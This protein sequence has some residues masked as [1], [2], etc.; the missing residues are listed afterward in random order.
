MTTKNNRDAGALAL[1]TGAELA[2][3]RDT[4]A[5]IH[6]AAAVYGL[7]RARLENLIQ[8]KEV[9]TP[10][11]GL[12]YH[13]ATLYP[14]SVEHPVTID[15]YLARLDR[16]GITTLKD[17]AWLIGKKYRIIS[18]YRRDIT[19]SP[20]VSQLMTHMLRCLEQ[21]PVEE[22]Q[23]LVAEVWDHPL[24]A[25]HLVALKDTWRPADL[26]AML[27]LD[28]SHFNAMSKRE[29]L[30]NSAGI[31]VRLLEHY[32]ELVPAIHTPQ[33][34][35]FKELLFRHGVTS[36]GVI[37]RL[38]GRVRQV[39]RNYLHGDIKPSGPV[40]AL[41]KLITRFL[42]THPLSEYMALVEAVSG[43]RLSIMDDVQRLETHQR[44]NDS[45]AGWWVL[46]KPEVHFTRDGD[47]IVPDW[48]GW[49][50]ERLKTLPGNP[51]IEVTPDWVC[52][53]LS[54]SN[55]Q[56]DRTLKLAFY[57]HCG[58]PYAWLINQQNHI[59]E[60]FTL[61]DGRYT[62]VATLEGATT[63]NVVPFDEVPIALADFWG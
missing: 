1:P 27:G 52:E 51:I 23:A 2:A 32:P 43:E 63:V 9:I 56:K 17:A 4:F 59:L 16:F 14:E 37:S 53:S 61:R 47:V 25:A 19:P 6:E 58:V 42:E 54:L 45:P 12:I 40:M 3:H 29:Y 55:M 41:M 8:G 44:V 60:A 30:A 21:R 20:L 62:L 48:A 11:I 31:F 26:Q 36:F 57:A 38:L 39:F 34:V 28:A 22:I 15:E 18:R 24:T 13:L 50:H 10:T 46:V 7:S 35:A 33:A 5:K 49:R